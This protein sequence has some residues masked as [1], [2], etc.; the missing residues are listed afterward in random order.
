[1]EELT[2]LFD[3]PQRSAKMV[4]G[5]GRSREGIGRRREAALDSVQVEGRRKNGLVG[6]VGPARSHQAQKAPTTTVS[7]G[8]LPRPT[9]T[10]S[11]GSHLSTSAGGGAGLQGRLQVGPA[12]FSL[13]SL[14]PSSSSSTGPWE[15]GRPAAPTTIAGGTVHHSRR[16]TYWRDQQDEAAPFR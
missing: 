3:L 10:A 1:M 2:G 11:G 9:A 7:G 6:G 4:E 5:R 14:A 16:P 8:R 12:P 15:E 13:S